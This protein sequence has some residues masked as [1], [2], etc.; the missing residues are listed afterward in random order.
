MRTKLTLALGLFG[1]AA[2]LG[3]AATRGGFPL[4]DYPAPAPPVHA[5]LASAGLAAEERALWAR[6]GAAAA[7]KPLLAALEA[8]V[9]T[10]TMFDLLSEEPWWRE[11]RDEFQVSRVVIHTGVLA[12][13]G[14]PD[15]AT[16][17][18]DVV[19]QARRD[20]VGSDLVSIAGARYALVASKLAARPEQGPVLVLAK[21]VNVAPPVPTTAAPQR[22]RGPYTLAL[23]TGGVFAALLALVLLWTTRVA[24]PVAPQSAA[25]ELLRSNEEEYDV[26]ASGQLHPRPPRPRT[27]V[28]PAIPHAHL[29]HPTS[30]DGMPVASD[31]TGGQRFGRY[32]LLNRI[33][34]GGM[35]EVFTAM[36][37]GVAGFKRVFVLKRLRPQLSRDAGAVAQFVDEARMQ[38]SLVHSNIVP[39]FDFGRV[40]DEYFMTQEYIV[41]RD[42][43]RVMAG[44]YDRHEET[45]GARFAMYVAHETL[46]ALQYAHTRL[47]TDGQ[48]LGIVHRDI[49]PG[50]V[51]V[52]AEGEVK[53]ADFGIVKSNRR[54]SQTQVGMVKGNANFMSPEQARGQPVDGR[55]D[56][57][58]VGLVLYYC[59]TNRLAYDGDNDL[60]VLYKA[61]SGPSAAV[62]EQIDALPSP[63]REALARALEVEPTHRFQSAAEFAAVLAPSLSGAKTEAARL[64]KELFG[65][66]LLREAA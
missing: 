20:G 50:N 35:S 43:G 1:L 14:K 21:R 6:V 41:G 23:A 29:R 61:A 36:T 40:G 59:L 7:T 42:L 54:T 18:G 53:L 16:Y 24:A 52:S 27:P 9:D 46:M 38:A 15:L 55:S 45:V 63:A 26:S 65:E 56:L 13:Q 44:Q 64:M 22:A 25:P 32:Q 19:A 37:N 3:V 33:G 49:S 39:V 28:T 60:E 17:D 4:A 10:A 11:V 62:R 34:E 5:S 31:G 30:P 58:S 57:F 48:P 8:G 51:I 2:G 66:A 12:T 47:D